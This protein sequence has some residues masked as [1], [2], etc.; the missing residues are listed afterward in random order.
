MTLS[1]YAGVLLINSEREEDKQKGAERES[2]GQVKAPGV[3]REVDETG[4][5]VRVD[6]VEVLSALDA[7]AR[8]AMLTGE[9]AVEG[10]NR[11]RAR[12]LEKD[13]AS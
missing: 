12:V 2:E 13:E 7:G 10:V 1:R 6:A 11:G 5:A 8:V 9:G 3:T 4:A